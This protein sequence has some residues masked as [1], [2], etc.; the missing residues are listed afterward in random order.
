MLIN[1]ELWHGSA[2]GLYMIN[3]PENRIFAKKKSIKNLNKTR[4]KS[5]I[6]NVIIIKLF[7]AL[8]KNCERQVARKYCCVKSKKAFSANSFINMHLKEQF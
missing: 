6:S 1:T 2:E 4:I 3:V 7:K 5:S 8:A